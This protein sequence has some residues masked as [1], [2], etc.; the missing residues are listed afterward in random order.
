MFNLHPL[1][2]DREAERLAMQAKRAAN[3]GEFTDAERLQRMAQAMHKRAEV[4]MRERPN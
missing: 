4:L 2:Y 1:A 3:L